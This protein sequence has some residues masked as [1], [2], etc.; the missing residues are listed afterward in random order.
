MFNVGL[1]EL[2]AI[3]FIALIFWGP[4]ALPELGKTLGRAVRT[5]RDIAKKLRDELGG[6]VKE[7]DELKS[8]VDDIRNPIATFTR[9]FVDV[10]FNAENFQARN[11]K[12]TGNLLRKR[13]EGDNNDCSSANITGNRDLHLPTDEDDYLSMLIEKQYAENEIKAQI[14]VNPESESH[15]PI[16]QP[17]CDDDYLNPVN[18]EVDSV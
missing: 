7:L 15:N 10:S 1:G 17:V 13:V 16:K 14:P 8:T 4:N 11:Q 3:F 12:H 5:V 2:I 9:E 18:C 6:S